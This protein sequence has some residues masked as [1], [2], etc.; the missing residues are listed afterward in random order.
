MDTVIHFDGIDPMLIFIFIVLMI[1]AI[2]VCCACGLI[3]HYK[4][5]PLDSDEINAA[6]PLVA[7]KPSKNSEKIEKKISEVESSSKELE[8]LNSDDSDQ[9]ETPL[10]YVTVHYNVHSK[11]ISM[12]TVPRIKPTVRF[13][14]EVTFIDEEGVEEIA[15]PRPVSSKIFF[16]S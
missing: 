2:W 6:S 8:N 13:A 3:R 7:T 15:R 5:K 4:T 10:K 14:E 12:E 9:E 16:L 11:K 1:V